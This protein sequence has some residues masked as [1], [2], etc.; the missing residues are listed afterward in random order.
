MG[1]ARSAKSHA[2]GELEHAGLI[3][4][5]RVAGRSGAGTSDIPAWHQLR[6]SVEDMAT[7]AR[8]GAGKPF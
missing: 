5:R 1:V 3:C 4:V 6:R 8:V 2:L 7:A